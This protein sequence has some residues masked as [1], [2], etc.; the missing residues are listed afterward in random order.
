MFALYILIIL[1]LAVTVVARYKVSSRDIKPLII[2]PTI[3]RDAH[4]IDS[5]YNAIKNSCSGDI[6]VITRITDTESIKRWESHNVKVITVPHYDIVRRHNQEE[7]SA[8]RNIG[9][10][11]A[12]DHRYDYVWFLDS[13]IVPTNAAYNVLVNGCESADICVI[14]YSV[15]WLGYPAIGVDNPPKLHRVNCGII[16][17]YYPCTIGGLGCTMIC[18]D[19]LKIRCKVVTLED[20]KDTVC[21]EDIGF[22]Q[23][24]IDEKIK[25]VYATGVHLIHN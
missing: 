25:A 6:L 5:Q 2:I 15:K 3:D 17:N 10:E 18:R 22:F 11:Y 13:D 21:G 14:P 7:L 4:L 1:L 19:A 23:A 12:A 8:K 9:L 20:G 24:C 16:T